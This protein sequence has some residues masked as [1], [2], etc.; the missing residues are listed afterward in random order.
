MNWKAIPCSDRVGRGRTR[1][2]R[3]FPLSFGFKYKSPIISQAPFSLNVP[4]FK[5]RP[6]CGLILLVTYVCF[7][8]NYELAGVNRRARLEL[9]GTLVCR[10]FVFYFG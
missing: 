10:V 3:D 7:E 2:A 5:T 9:A 6:S 8:L 1:V 4:L